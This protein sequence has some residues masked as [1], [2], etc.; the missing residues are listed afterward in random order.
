MSIARS[1]QKNSS[2]YA[3]GQSFPTFRPRLSTYGITMSKPTLSSGAAA[4]VPDV[5]I[6]SVL[7]KKPVFVA[8]QFVLL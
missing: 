4:M 3:G 6:R 5:G 7:T 8:P 2:V 1:A